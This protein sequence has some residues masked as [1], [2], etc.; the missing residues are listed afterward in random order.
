MITNVFQAQIKCFKADEGGEFHKLEPYL[1]K[2]G[3]PFRYFRPATPQQNGVA[4]RKHR[5]VAEKMRCLLFQSQLPLVFWVEALHYAIFLI[6]RLPSPSL[7]HKSPYQ[8]LF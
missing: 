4:E 5:H 7:S 1:T 3:I 2:H 8:I 6:N